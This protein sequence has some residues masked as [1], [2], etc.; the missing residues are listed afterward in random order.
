[1]R[2]TTDDNSVVYSAEDKKALRNLGKLKTAAFNAATLAH[3]DE[4]MQQDAKRAMGKY[5]KE[6]K[7]CA[8][9]GTLTVTKDKSGKVIRIYNYLQNRTWLAYAPELKTCAQMGT[10]KNFLIFFDKIEYD[11]NK[12]ICT[13]FTNSKINSMFT[14]NDITHID[15]GVYEMDIKHFVPLK[16]IDPPAEI[17]LDDYFLFSAF[18]HG[19]QFKR[20]RG[21]HYNPWNRDSIDTFESCGLYSYYGPFRESKAGK[22]FMLQTDKKLMEQIGNASYIA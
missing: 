19:C 7:R 9:L 22:V 16:V 5:L 1:M 6:A 12:V 20:I 2:E 15:G 18:Q 14:R 11:G 4:S 13:D 10:F 21:F 8:M 3:D 17:K